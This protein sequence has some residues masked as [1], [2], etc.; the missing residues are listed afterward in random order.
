MDIERHVAQLGGFAATHEL[1]ALGWTRW[2]LRAAVASE[3]VIR[4]RQGWYCSPSADPDVVAAFRVGGRL[5]CVSAAFAHGLA[6]WRPGTVHV[7]VPENSCRHRSPADRRR[8][9]RESPG[10]AVL[11]WSPGWGRPTG[12]ASVL[13]CL[14]AMAFCQSPERVVA[15]VDS[16]L[17]LGLLSL[18]E[19]LALI[20]DLPRRLRRLLAQVDARSGSITES[21]VRFRLAQLGVEV[22][23]QVRFT[24]VG[25]VDFVIGTR[26]VLEIDGFAYHSD[27]EQ[28][29]RDRRRDARLSARGYRVLR[30]SYRQVT[31]RWSEVKAAV[32]G[33]IARGDHL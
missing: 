30:F 9:L 24:G 6:V 33:A 16:A 10:A 19:W 29:E 1:Y 2:T 13:E 20:E 21:L 7:E 22:R 12:C 27:P 14:R 25:L 26:L 4:V 31:S 17:R 8:R 15:A 28:F 32:F 11:H 5:G 23:S 3:R 18:H